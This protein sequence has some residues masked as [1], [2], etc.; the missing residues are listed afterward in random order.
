MM[1]PEQ[2]DLSA[3]QHA[4]LVRTLQLAENGTLQH[5]QFR[6]EI[7]ANDDGV[8][9]PGLFN[10]NVWNGRVGCGTVHCLAGTAE[11]VAGAYLFRGRE[12]QLPLQLDRLFWCA[13]SP[14]P[15]QYV[16]VA[17]AARALRGYLETGVT[18]WPEACREHA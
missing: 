3:A 13:F 8:G 17:Q 4:A 10:M 6:D 5:W 9:T 11:A 7:E 14:V 15:M 18:D 2:L 1:T 12:L 16:T